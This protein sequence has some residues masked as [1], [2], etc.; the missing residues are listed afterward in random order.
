V[1]QRVAIGLLN[2]RGHKVV[3]A[4]NGQEAIEWLTRRHFDLVLMDVQMPVMDGFEATIAIRENERTTGTHIP[5]IAMT[6]SAMKGDRELCLK[7]GMD[8]Y[9][10][11]PIN[12]RELYDAV[13]HID[14]A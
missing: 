2:L 3:V 5:I 6:A 11:K 12:A 7:A 4:N 9:L 10:S 8:G 14:R 13:E 1:N